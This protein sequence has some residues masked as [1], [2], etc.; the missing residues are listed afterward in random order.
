MKCYEIH[1]PCSLHGT[2]ELSGAKNA[3]LPIIVAAF[4]ADEPVTLRGLP[5]NLK[6]V[7][8]L[9]EIFQAMGAKFHV[10]GSSLHIEDTVLTEWQLSSELALRIRYSLL[11]LGLLLGRKGKVSIGIPGGCKLGDRKFDLHLEGLKKLGASITQH[12]DRIEGHVDKLVGAEIELPIATTS[13]TENIMLAACFAKGHTSIL[14]AHTRPEVEDLANFLNTLGAKITIHNRRI[15]I[16]GVKGFSGGDYTIMKAWD[17]AVTFIAAAGI[18]GAEIRIKGFDLSTIPGDAF[19]LKNAGVELYEWGGDL[20]VKG[21]SSLK[22][23]HLV[24]GPYPIVNSDMQPIFAAL[25]SQ[26][27]GESTVTD[28]RFPER[29][30][31]VG[32]FR[33]MGMDIIQFGNCAVVNGGCQLHGAE[34]TALDLRCGASLVIA[35]LVAKGKTRINNIY[36]IERGYENFDEKCQGLG[37]DIRSIAV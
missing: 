10:D 18:C 29:F 35:A 15:E 21:P 22:P 31:Y 32:E 25:A 4:A 33:R 17:E 14:N 19:L 16:D 24:T 13:G 9:L 1:G 28:Q 8:A 2:V 23:I 26:A 30:G 34:V 6:D 11:L 20:Y 5:N 37:I 3:A 12:E 27:K 7:K 36:Q